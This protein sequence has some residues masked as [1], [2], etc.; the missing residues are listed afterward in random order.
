MLRGRRHD[1]TALLCAFDVLEL[2]GNDL[3]RQPLETRK[4]VLSRLLRDAPAGVAVNAHYEAEGAAVY[5]HACALGCEGIVSKQLGS[6]YRSGRGW[7]WLKI[8]NPN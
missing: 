6:P 1:H 7:S 8:K 4:K 5:K 3:R 2:D